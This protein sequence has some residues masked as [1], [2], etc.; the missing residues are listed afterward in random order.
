MALGVEANMEVLK[1]SHRKAWE[2]KAQANLMEIQSPKRT[3]L[4]T[5]GVVVCKVQDS[6]LAVHHRRLGVVKL[7]LLLSR[8]CQM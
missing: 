4:I 1:Q 6:M 8:R 3:I 7:L 5:K 2:A